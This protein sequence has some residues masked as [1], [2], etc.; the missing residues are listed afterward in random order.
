MVGVKCQ[1][2]KEKFEDHIPCISLTTIAVELLLLVALI[3]LI[4]NESTAKYYFYIVSLATL[5]V[6][7]IYF[8]WH[9]LV[10][11]N[12]FELL[13]FQVMSS[14]LNFHGIYMVALH[15]NV[16]LFAIAFPILILSQ[17]FYYFSFWF[18]YKRFGWRIVQ[19]LQTSNLAMIKGFKY[20]E[21]FVSVLKLDFLLYSLTIAS[22]IYYISVDWKDFIAP[23]L[24]ISLLIYIA[25]LLVSYLGL[26]SATKERTKPFNLFLVFA[27][28]C[29]LFKALCLVLLALSPGESI[30]TFI[31]CQALVIA[32]VD[33]AIAGVLV[34]LGKSI[35][36]N[37]G[38]GLKSVIRTSSDDMIKAPFVGSK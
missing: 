8:A 34:F 25:M 36:K 7:T 33:I 2:L 22:F 14:I 23:G 20:Y 1:Q 5:M 37:F 26:Y 28:V 15:G 18:A 6:G 16:A 31:L 29:Q 12:A 32:V 24:V 21:V 11:E 9:S 4:Y 38:R 17:M 27:P 3:L 10:K 19:E 13:A 35:K 30:D